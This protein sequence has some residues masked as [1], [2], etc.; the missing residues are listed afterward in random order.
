[1][2]R[3]LCSHLHISRT[4]ATERQNWGLSHLFIP[5]GEE[6][7][8]L[9]TAP[10]SHILFLMSVMG[11]VWEEPPKVWESG[12]DSR[13]A[14]VLDTRRGCLPSCKDPMDPRDRLP[15]HCCPSPGLP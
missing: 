12:A 10:Y 5:L 4:P 3:N 15:V 6:H 13:W 7:C 9:V 11:R 2:N 14:L 8:I 1:M